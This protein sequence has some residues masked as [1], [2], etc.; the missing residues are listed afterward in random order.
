MI[1]VTLPS[2]ANLKMQ[3]STFKISKALYQAVLKELKRL[4]YSMQTDLPVILKDVFCAAFSSQEIEEC[5][6]ECFKRCTIN[7]LKIDESTFEKEDAREDYMKVCMEVG[8]LNI[9]PFA[10]SHFAEFQQLSVIL[11]SAL[12]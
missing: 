8:K 5:L 1:E 11:G 6:W 3:M 7:D 10:K 9:I 12:G 2:G 4:N